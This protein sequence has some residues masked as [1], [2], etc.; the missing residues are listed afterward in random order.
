MAHIGGIPR[1]TIK[2]AI[3]YSTGEYGLISSYEDANGKIYYFINGLCKATIE[4]PKKEES[5]L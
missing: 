4:A 1:K 5:N 2:D 3:K